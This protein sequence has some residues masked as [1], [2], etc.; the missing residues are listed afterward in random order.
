MEFNWIS[1]NRKLFR[2]PQNPGRNNINQGIKIQIHQRIKADHL[3]MVRK[4]KRN[5]YTKQSTK[6]ENEAA[7]ALSA[8]TCNVSLES[9]DG[10][11]CWFFVVFIL[12]DFV[13]RLF[14]RLGFD[15][16]VSFGVVVVFIARRLLDRATPE[17]RHPPDYTF[18]VRR[19]ICFVVCVVYRSREIRTRGII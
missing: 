13:V 12:F 16:S 4:E 7:P 17:I 5:E 15:L 6:Q 19:L 8:G 2:I 9:D 3:I 1:T 11:Q 18:S 10:T 14:L